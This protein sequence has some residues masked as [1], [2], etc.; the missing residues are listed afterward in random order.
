[1]MERFK[2]RGITHLAVHATSFEPSVSPIVLARLKQSPYLQLLAEDGG[3]NI[4]EVDYSAT[5]EQ[6]FEPSRLLSTVQLRSE[7]YGKFMYLDGWYGR[8]VYPDQRPFRWMHGVQANGVVFSGEKALSSVRLAYSCPLEG[9]TVMVNGRKVMRDAEN[10]E[11][12]WK[13]MTIN[14]PEYGDES[15]LFEFITP[16][17]FKAPPD[18]RDF[19]CMIGDID[20]R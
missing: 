14:L 20:I 5:G 3:V 1:M 16:K 2:L 9:L 18:T 7:D 13:Q 11:G 4:F 12:G 17:L 10:L 19:G 6:A 8:E 15:Y